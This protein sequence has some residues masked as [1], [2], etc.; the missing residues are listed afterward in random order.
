MPARDFINDTLLP[1]LEQEI[2]DEARGNKYYLRGFDDALKGFDSQAHPGAGGGQVQQQRKAAV[3]LQRG[4][5]QGEDAG[6]QGVLR[7]GDE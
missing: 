2:A 4:V 7:V 1:W 5:G 3:R 6:R